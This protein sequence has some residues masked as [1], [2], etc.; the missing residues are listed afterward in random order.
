M[1]E[2]HHY[3]VA[4]FRGK[5]MADV[6]TGAL[7]PPPC[8]LDTLNAI[9]AHVEQRAQQLFGQPCSR[10]Q[11]LTAFKQLLAEGVINPA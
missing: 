10:M 9:V 6:D 3:F 7:P 11:Y 5:I 8:A 1:V 2:L 4:L